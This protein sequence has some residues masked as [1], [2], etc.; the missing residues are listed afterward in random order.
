MADKS[1]VILFVFG[2]CALIL[3]FKTAQLQIINSTYKEQARKTTLDKTI[4]YP[5]RGLI[6]DRN[7]KLLVSNNAIYDID[8]IYNNV[9]KKIDTV[10][11]CSLL[12]IDKKT[13][14]KQ[15]NKDWKNIQYHKSIPFTFLTRIKPEQFSVFQEH[16]HKFP[17][18]YPIERNIRTYP[19]ENIAHVLGF[20]GEVDKSELNSDENNTYARGD[21]IGRSGLERTYEG[22]LKGQK[23]VGYV[24]K[25]NLGRYVESFE[26]GRLDSSAISGSDIISTID[27]DLQKY[28]EAL[29]QNKMGSI[30]ALEPSTGEIL[31][32]LSSPSYNPNLLN[33]DRNRGV[34]YDSLSQDTLYRP[35]FDRSVMAKY[36][37]GSIF[38]TIFSLIAMQKNLLHPKRTI[39]CDGRY[40]VD[41]KGLY[42][43]K[44]HQHPTPYNVSIALQHSCNTYYYQLLREFIDSHGYTTPGVGLD[45]LVSYLN[46]FGLG[47][48]LGIDYHTEDSGFLP[49]SSFYDN[50]Y[51]HI[52]N[53]WRSTYI[54][55]LGI[56]QGELEFTTIQMANLAAI[57]ANKGYYYTPHLVKSFAKEE[58]QLKEE[59]VIPKRVRIDAEHFDPVIDGMSKVTT[60]GTGK[61]A[62]IPGI[63]L[64]GKTG[65][66]ENRGRDHSVFFAF[67]PKENPKIALAVYVENAGFGGDIAA[68][69]ASLMIEKY[70]NGSIT[71][72]RE[73]LED[74]M[75]NLKLINPEQDL[76]SQLIRQ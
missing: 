70:L 29:M 27:L 14:I 66:S 2:I 1:K 56:G 71:K 33:L 6:Y 53:G 47:Q 76:L 39:Y 63:E 24:L 67:A 16:L 18:F 26:D 60:L 74:R 41:S 73:Y 57:I 36:P 31:T 37:P 21:Y 3:T 30:V 40:E 55:S 34:S 11:I 23:G 12:G 65:T 58:F 10:E 52:R 38:K 45:T 17:G 43:Q 25:D 28:G 44:C 61:L 22:E 15:I 64:C 20:L 4:K 49:S 19:H 75:L 50:L 8:V 59:F 72:K 9:P 7:G 13:F 35:L 51:S 42:V 48:E 32:M 54:L 62:Y 68:P 69:I 5:A 46:E